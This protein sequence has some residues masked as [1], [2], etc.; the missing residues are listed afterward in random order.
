[1][2]QGL[3]ETGENWREKI[4]DLQALLA[5]IQ[6]KLIDAEARLAERFAEISR[7]EFKLRLQIEPLVQRLE[8]LK[9][10]IRALRR[11]LR[12]MQEDWFFARENDTD[13]D[14]VMADWNFDEEA[15][16]AAAGDYRYMGP[17]AQPPLTD[18]SEDKQDAIKRLYR[19][20]ARRFHPDL[21]RDEAERAYRTDIMMRINAAYAAGDLEKLQAIAAEPDNPSHVDYA[22]TDQQLAAAMLRELVRCRQRL[23][24]IEKE[25]ASLSQHRNAILLR[26]AQRAEASGYDLLAEM[27]LELQEEIAQSM[28]ERDIL[29]QEIESFSFEQPEMAPDTFAD[30]ILDLSLE[31]MFDEDDD[32]LAAKDWTRR[33]SNWFHHDDDD[34][35]DDLD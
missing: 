34:I 25:F 27:A 18:L 14:F 35:L 33:R 5:D 4:A 6:P 12:Q 10:E 11:Q 28:V 15:G 9:N 8:A 21:A 19:Q 7:F 23:A 3:A 20:L 22:Q 13:S 32:F 2:E 30:T 26:R 1:M 24:E 17:R 16:A 29:L 31:Q